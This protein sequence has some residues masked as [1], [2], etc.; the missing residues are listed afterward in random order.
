M[1]VDVDVDDIGAR[2]AFDEVIQQAVGESRV[3]LVM[4]SKRWPSEREGL[5]Q[6]NEPGDFGRPEVAAARGQGPARDPA[7]DPGL[8]FLTR[9]GEIGERAGR[10][11]AETAHRYRGRLVG[12]EIRFVMQTEG[13]SSSHGPVEFVARRV[14][15]G[16]PAASPAS[17]PGSS[18][19]PA[20]A[21]R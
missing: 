20:P 12:D 7:V 8:R 5:S 19:P 9:T 2:L 11:V 13:G 15:Q 10:T 17:S 16:P 3:L 4:I 18:R 6:I 21:S 14:A 1:D